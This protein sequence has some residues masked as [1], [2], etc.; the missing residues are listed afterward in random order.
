MSWFKDNS[1]FL[2]G[3]LTKTLFLCTPQNRLIT[4]IDTS[5]LL[6]TDLA[7][8]SEKVCYIF[9]RVRVTGEEL[10]DKNV[11][12]VSLKLNFIAP[13][14]HMEVWESKRTRIECF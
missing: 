9:D 14:Y 4:F 8:Y 1:S 7:K 10:P 5:D 2:A 13:P 12:I 11:G 6:M 3:K